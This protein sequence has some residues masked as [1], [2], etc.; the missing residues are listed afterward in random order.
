MDQ[1][2]RVLISGASVGGPTVAYWLARWGCSVTVVERMSLSRVRTGGHAVDLFGPALDVAE[3]T[4]VLPAVMEARTQTEVVSFQ[5]E[6]GRGVDL[7]MT[8]LVAGIS[9][10]HVE[11]M[12]GELAAALYGASQDDVDYRF[13]DS[14]R[15][16]DQQPDGVVVT[17]ENAPPERFD[18]VI[19]ADGLHSIVRRLVFG[20]EDRFLQ[21]LGGYLAIF[22]LPDYVGLGRR[23]IVHNGPGR[24]AALYPVRQTGQARAGFLF[25]RTEELPVDHHDITEQKRLLRGVY[26]GDR[27]QVPRLL[28]EMDAA[29]DF[30]FDSISQVVMPAWSQGRVTLVGDAG[31]SPGP[32]VGG[33]T[34]L[35]MV[36]AYV[37]AREIGRATDL[38]GGLRA[39]ED[40]MHDCV[41]AFR[42][43]G[44]S[45]MKTLI[46]QTRVGARLMPY[47]LGGLTRL[48]GP[49]Q[50]RLSRLQATPATALNAVHLSPP[51]MAV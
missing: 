25:R 10:R 34:S 20:D 5:R 33:G 6:D 22:V 18:L 19:G 40:A 44:P 16:L 30:Y 15:T 42:K 24:L 31:Y 46:P 14:I 21:F 49:I 7:D 28:D 8:R 27:W 37:L 9:H 1:P 23:M 43:I 11:V 39:Y 29:D 50:A 35:A 47:V 48:P 12:R 45:V 17:F 3:W 13:E 4:G 38:E 36:G 32:A 2:M 26:R 51:P 41:L